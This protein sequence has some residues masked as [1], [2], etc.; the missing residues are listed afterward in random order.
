M[1]ENYQSYKVDLNKRHHS[2]DYTG[3]NAR[4]VPHLGFHKLLNF[5]L[6]FLLGAIVGVMIPSALGAVTF[7]SLIE[8]NAESS[9][10]ASG[11]YEQVLFNGE[12]RIDVYET[13]KKE[14]GYQ[15]VQVVGD[16][17]LSTGHGPEAR[18]RSY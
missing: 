17:V 15:I 16:N 1:T 5:A 13:P 14:F 18:E 12:Y 6:G 10:L 2:Y 4:Q 11:A 9:R 8:S 3:S 7:L